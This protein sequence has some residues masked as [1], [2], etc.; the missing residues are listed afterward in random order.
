[1]NAGV[2]VRLVC[3]WAFVAL[4]PPANGQ[5][6]PATVPFAGPESTS[7]FLEHG[8]PPAS[9]PWEISATGVRRFGLV[10]LETRAISARAGW[11]S[12]RAAAGI[13]QTG[14]PELG[15]WSCA[16]AS[17]FA[18][19]A[20]GAAVRVIAR[21]DRASLPSAYQASLPSAY[22]ASLP[23]DSQASAYQ[24]SEFGG[25]AWIAPAP[26]LT[27]WLASPHVVRRGP[28]PP[29]RRGL[30]IGVRGSRHG[31][32]AW[33]ARESAVDGDGPD[34]HRGGGAWIA[35]PVR[36]ALELREAPLRASLGVSVR[37][38]LLSVTAA[39]DEHPILPG[40]TRLGMS[41]GSEP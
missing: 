27:V 10:E 31:L 29:L 38:G 13:S 3:A 28:P 26:G 9:R 34:R 39:V 22:Q 21:R 40:T 7:E 41:L 24:A 5:D 11:K 14:G 16:A 2:T 8:L 15:W 23:S 20:G 17:G 4:A 33:L 35:G 32:E 12:V 36:V 30:E 37:R 6:F 18:T 25:G 1:V 19:A